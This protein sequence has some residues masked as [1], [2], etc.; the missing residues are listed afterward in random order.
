MTVYIDDIMVTMPNA[1]L[2]DLEWTRRLLKRTGIEM[3]RGKSKIF[4]KRATK[5]I[6]GVVIQKGHT[7]APAYQHRKIKE[8]ETKLATTVDNEEKKRIA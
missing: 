6:T 4:P 3:H 7:M 2:T 8:L 1:S 5:I